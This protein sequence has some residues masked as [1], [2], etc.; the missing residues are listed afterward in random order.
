MNNEKIIEYFNHLDRSFFLEDEYKEYA[1]FDEPI[2]IGFNQTMSQPSLV[3]KMTE[4]L[5]LHHSSKVLEIGTGSGFQ[6]A[7]LAAFASEVYTVELIEELSNKAQER[8]F[9]LDFK[10]IT[11]KVGDGTMGFEEH[12]PFERIIVTAAAS[13]LPEN[14][15]KQLRKGGKMLI[16]LGNEHEQHLF[17]F[18]KGNDGAVHKQEL[19]SVVFV[20]LKGSKGWS[21]R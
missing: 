1:T 11:Y 19:Q 17:L 10:N 6:T 20:E 9:A 18:E 8:L 21:A 16:P 7:L 12:A 15:W 14:L 3:L 2:P 13:S 4:A 5:D